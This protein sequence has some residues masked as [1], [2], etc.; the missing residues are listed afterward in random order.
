MQAPPK[1]RSS[2]LCTAFSGTRTW[3][4][5]AGECANRIRL[6]RHRDDRPP[7]E[8]VEGGPPAGLAIAPDERSQFCAYF[9]R[10]DLRGAP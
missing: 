10:N 8:A 6:G 5:F 1:I 9:I 3:I 4:E 2:G 7:P